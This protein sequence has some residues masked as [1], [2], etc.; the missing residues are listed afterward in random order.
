MYRWFF[1]TRHLTVLFFLSNPHGSSVNVTLLSAMNFSVGVTNIMLFCLF[2]SVSMRFSSSSFILVLPIPLW[3][4]SSSSMNPCFGLLLSS[5]AMNSLYSWVI[6]LLVSCGSMNMNI[7]AIATLLFL[8]PVSPFTCATTQFF[9]FLFILSFT[10]SCMI[11]VMSFFFL[12][13]LRRSFSYLSLSRSISLCSGISE[14]CGGIIF[15]ISM[16]SSSFS[17]LS[18]IASF[19]SCSFLMVRILFSSSCW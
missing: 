6:C 18:V 4:T 5:S 16:S 3:N 1:L 14:Y 17:S 19:F 8:L 13:T 12:N 15:Y 9:S 11:F 10:S 2:L 7:R